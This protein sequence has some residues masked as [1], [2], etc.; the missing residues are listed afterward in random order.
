[1]SVPKAIRIGILLGCGTLA[2]AAPP[3]A[4]F[5][6]FA[7]RYD[8]IWH[9]MNAGT[10]AFALQRLSDNEWTYSSRTEPRGLFRLFSSANATLQ[11]R[12]SIG[13]DG[14]RPLHFSARQGSSAT[15]TAEVDFDWQQLRATGRMDNAN[16]EVALRAGVQD[17]LSVQVALIHALVNGTTPTG[18]ALFDQAGVRDYEY[19]QV[20][21]ETLHTPLGDIDT[22]IYRSHRSYSPRSTRFWCAPAYGYIP[23]RAQQHHND[24]VEWTMELRSL[25]RD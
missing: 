22:I 18:I 19:S 15:T 24:E 10:A 4:E 23:V 11:S 17:D 25:Q 9:D 13:P 20:G 3:A 8:F 16:V 1:M 6:P 5:R 14:V 7:T 12:M 21:T 2:L